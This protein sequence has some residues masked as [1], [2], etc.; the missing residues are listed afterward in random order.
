ML[1][2]PNIS[3]PLDPREILAERARQ[4]DA[5]AVEMII[6]LLPDPLPSTPLRRMRD[7]AIYLVNNWLCRYLPGSSRHWRACILA[8]AG[9]ILQTRTSLPD[10]GRFALL[11]SAELKQLANLIRPALPLCRWPKWRKMAEI[12]AK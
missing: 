6:T 4:G 9:A 2:G 7:E 12:L 3:L 11:D 5:E 1:A 8:N 10:S